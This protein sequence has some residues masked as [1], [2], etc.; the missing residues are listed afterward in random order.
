[1]HFILSFIILD[2]GVDY[3]VK[4]T[5]VKQTDC[6][7]NGL[8]LNTTYQTINRHAAYALFLSL[9]STPLLVMAVSGRR[10]VKSLLGTILL[11]T[12]LQARANP[13][14]DPIQWIVTDMELMSLVLS[15]Q[16]MMSS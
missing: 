8:R 2:T 9:P 6:V 5:N 13:Y 7:S 4:K 14:Q 15:R 16:T 1:V 3:N 11:V 10:D 12:R